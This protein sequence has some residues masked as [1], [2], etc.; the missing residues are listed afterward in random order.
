MANDAGYLRRLAHELA[1]GQEIADLDRRLRPQPGP[2]S[3]LPIRPG[4]R[5]LED[6]WTAI[7]RDDL[8][9]ALDDGADPATYEANIENAIGRTAVPLGLAGPV[10]VRGLHAADDHWLPLATSEAALV[11]SVHRGAILITRA[12]GCTALLLAEGVTRSPVFCFQDVPVAGHFI[13][14]VLDQEEVLREVAATTT[15]HGS[16]ERLR[17]TIE[18][19]RVYLLFDFKTGDAAGQNMV[20]IATQKICEHIVAH[21]PVRPEYWFVEANASGDKKACAQS[22]ESVRG[23]KVTAEVRIEPALIRRYL[24]TTPAAMVAYY[25]ASAMGGVLAGGIGIQGHYANVLAALFIATGQ[26]A[27][28][29]AEAA[30]GVTRMQ[31]EEDGALRAVV[32]LPNLIVGSVGGG[33]GLPSQRAALDLMGCA[34]GGRARA[35]AEVCAAAVL[36][37]E[38]SIVGAL[39]CG[40]F[41]AAHER[42]ARHRRDGKA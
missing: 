25:E 19:N 42:L 38:L 16:L 27:A 35:L 17:V 7:G 32:T 4:R 6:R 37:G 26:D 10:R 3:R 15:R 40:E 23:R 14:W 24:H 12:G 41:T 29:A 33:T 2:G 22:F 11:A 34:G 39:S 30:V 9:P 13:L 1:A 20:T 18:G 36:A 21:S 31:V 8:R 5:G 28:C